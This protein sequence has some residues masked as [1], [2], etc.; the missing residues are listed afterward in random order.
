M[1]KAFRFFMLGSLA[2]FLFSFPAA[3]AVWFGE[4]PTLAA[5]IL[6]SDAGLARGC[7]AVMGAVVLLFLWIS[8]KAFRNGRKPSGIGFLLVAGGGASFALLPKLAVFAVAGGTGAIIV[9][10]IVGYL[11]FTKDA[12]KSGSKA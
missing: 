8:L 12:P 10:F 11:F 4:D 2:F 6:A 9:L 7:A 1:A 3:L 5:N